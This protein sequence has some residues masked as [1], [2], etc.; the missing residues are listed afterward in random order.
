[1]RKL[2][3]NK[4][5][6]AIITLSI[7]AVSIYNIPLAAAISYEYEQQ[8]IMF[9]NEDL[10]CNVNVQG[11]IGSEAL[12]QG[13]GDAG[14]MAQSVVDG[15]TKIGVSVYGNWADDNGLSAYGGGLAGSTSFAEL[16]TPGVSPLDFKYFADFMNAPAD[17]RETGRWTGYKPNSKFAISYTPNNEP[18]DDGNIIIAE[19]RD[20]GGNLGTPFIDGAPRVMDLWHETANLLGWTDYG[21][22]SMWVKKVPDSTPVTPLNGGPVGEIPDGV[23]TPGST[24]NNPC[25]LNQIS[26]AG[27]PVNPNGY[28]FPVLLP[29]SEI[30]NF[31]TWPCPGVCHHDGTGAMDLTKAPANDSGT[32]VPVLAIRGGTIRNARQSYSGQQG[33]NSFQLQADDGF[34]YWYGHI[35]N[36]PAEGTQVAAG[37]PV[38]IIGER[39]CTGNGSAPHLHIDRGWPQGRTGGSVGSRDPN[40]PQLINQLYA[41]LP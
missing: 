31:H 23:A 41:D 13:E 10:G 8:E 24:D 4:I 38:G 27:G 32:G 17:Q 30:Y 21:L 37:D 18:P 40:L 6:L 3:K 29:K 9:Y 2:I 22:T 35:Q 5:H 39:R 15:W 20:R 11:L 36:I 34:Y 26:G 7:A 25:A 14:G 12:E 28:A 1:M 19:K 16:S 33:C